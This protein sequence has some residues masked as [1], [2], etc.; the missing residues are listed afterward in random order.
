MAEMLRANHDKMDAWLTEKQ[1]G[2]K[3]TIACHER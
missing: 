1:D 3:E 2:Q